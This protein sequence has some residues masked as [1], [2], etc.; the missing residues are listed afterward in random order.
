MKKS[1]ALVLITLLLSAFVGACGGGG[2]AAAP[3]PVGPMPPVAAQ[4]PGGIWAG[5]SAT[6]ASPDVFTSFEFNAAG[7][8][9]VGATP[10]RATFSSGRAE[11][12]GIP[13]FYIT[14]A[15]SWHILIGTSATVT[16][17]TLPS[18][19]NFHVRMPSNAD[20]GEVRILDENST[21]IQ[22]IVPT[23]A[24][25]EVTVNRAAGQTLIG[26][27]EVTSTGGGDIVIDDFTFGFAQTTDDIGCLVSN[28]LVFA[29][30]ITDE[31][32]GDILASAQG[33]VTIANGNQVSG[34]GTLFAAPGQTLSDGSTA[35]ALTISGGTV[36]EANTLNLTISAAGVTSTIST[37]FDATYDRGSD[38]AT[39]A[40]VYTTFDIFGDPSSF[41]IDAAGDITGQSN[42]G[43]VL[44][45]QVLIIDPLFNTYDVSL[46]VANCGALDG[47]YA[48][49]GTSQD[50]IVMDDTFVFAVFTSQT[51]IVGVAEK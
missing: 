39:I 21:L 1:L 42:S 46:D 10:F 33:T 27:V 13:S 9:S 2:G 29:C 24:F 16:F 40:A 25:Q 30:V 26:S 12:R 15:N 36:S 31:T 14:G 23:G 17:E 20:V 32:T 43:C 34:S 3:P 6:A 28:T 50:D 51:A 18:S 8:F 38:L 49:L 48:G 5:Q 37:T 7:P 35:A 22:T 19:V 4:D 11:T 47:M 44:N 45:G 41:T